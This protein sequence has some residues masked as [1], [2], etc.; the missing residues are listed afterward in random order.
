MM[1]LLSAPAS[2]FGRKVK[3][4]AKLKGLFE[5]ISVENID[6]SQ[7]ANPALKARNPLQKIPVLILA[8]GTELYDSHVICEYLDSL[9]ADPRL[10]PASGMARFVTL[11]RGALASGLMDAAVLL[12]YEHRFRPEDMRSEA[13]TAR[14]QSKV[15]QT[16]AHLEA[17]PPKWSGQPD[18][19]D[20][21]LASALG[22][23][24]FRHGGKWR[25]NHPALVAWLGLF[26]RSV[27]AFDETAPR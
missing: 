9:V 1:T 14:Q 6:T 27:P 8:D 26:G 13:W 20:I 17:E 19:G 22:Y 24:D 21:S 11:R 5:Q 7:P 4:T 23:L 2:P 16:L 18:Y 15:D 3:I 10:I 25:T 12:V